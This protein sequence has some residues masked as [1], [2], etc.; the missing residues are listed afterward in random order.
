MVRR[1]IANILW[2]N[3]LKDIVMVIPSLRADAMVVR[4][5]KNL[6]TSRRQDTSRLL[7]S[8][9][10]ISLLYFIMSRLWQRNFYSLAFNICRQHVALSCKFRYVY[11]QEAFSSFLLIR[12][13]AVACLPCMMDHWIMG[14]NRSL[15]S[16]C[17]V[18]SVLTW[19]DWVPFS[20]LNC[21][22]YC[23]FTY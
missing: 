7:L 5:N 19:T 2:I 11:Q 9:S 21:D 16:Y 3:C 22:C 15:C 14:W 10:I 20:A 12:S 13:S 6:Q 1:M 4:C 17:S 8:L 18:N 23:R